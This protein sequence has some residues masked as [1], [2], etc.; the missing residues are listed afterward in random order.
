MT[1]GPRAADGV[2]SMVIDFRTQRERMVA[3]QIEG[4]GVRDPLVT[5]AM[6]AVP[7][8]YFVAHHRRDEAYEDY[9]IPIGAGQTISQPY[10]VGY[11]IA[12]LNLEGGEKVLEVGAGSG[13]AAAVLSRI[14][15]EVYAIERIDS[16]AH[17]AVAN[18][19]TAGC[20]NVHVRCADGS[21]GW[22]EA[23]P[24]DAILVSAGAPKAPQP[25]L[26]QLAIGGRLVIP[27]GD[28]PRTQDLVRIT[29]KGETVFASET[30]TGVRFVPLIGAEG[31]T[32]EQ[33]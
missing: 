14:A 24:F 26:D 29:R 15:R 12:C 9:P 3:D 30:L 27:I 5:A 33:T 6:R 28:D 31:W 11:M 1:T 4:R 8:E 13:Y 16:L 20:T 32:S 18:L 7:R 25:L 19:K 22:P 23:A 2:Y 17:L 21:K 10:I